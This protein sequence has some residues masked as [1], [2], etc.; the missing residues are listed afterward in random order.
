VAVAQT[1]FPTVMQAEAAAAVGSTAQVAQEQKTK[2]TQEVLLR[3]QTRLGV[4]AAAVLEAS[5]YQAQLPVTLATEGR[6]SVRRLPAAALKELVEAV[7]QTITQPRREMRLAVV[8][9]GIT[10][11]R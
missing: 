4:A 5:A 1:L 11:A 6:A 7:V 8:G 2:A 10:P 9:R 3:N